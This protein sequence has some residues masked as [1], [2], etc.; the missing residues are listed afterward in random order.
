L[1]HQHASLHT[2][3]N[4]LRMQ[5]LGVQVML[6]FQFDALFQDALQ[7]PGTHEI[8][9]SVAGFVF[10]VLALALLLGAPSAHRLAEHGQPTARIQLL[11]QRYAA[12]ALVGLSGAMAA[13]AYL[14]SQ[15]HWGTAFAGTLAATLLVACGLTWYVFGAFIAR[16]THKRPRMTDD[17]GTE[18]SLSAEVDDLLTE[19]RVALPGAQALLGFQFIVTM[20]RPFEALPEVVKAIH[21]VGLACVTSSVL[22]LI[23]TAAI[24]RVAFGGRDVA[25]FL[26]I[27]S[28]VVTL[29]LAPLALG[30]AADVYVAAFKLFTND[31]IAWLS[32]GAA[33]AVLATFW[34]AIP[35]ALRTRRY[36]RR[37][38]GETGTNAT[39]APRSSGSARATQA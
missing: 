18:A 32:A 10:V 29:A 17:T 6:G 28:S 39:C 3:L 23:S 16:R 38:G 26:R 30:I 37:C 22:L 14:I 27:G 33:L 21:F 1:S 24:H 31:A 2:A 11:T 19:A 25:E 15:R 7:E 4:E 34:Y 20:T 12:G 5:M 36:A 35:L 8:A 13:N 9:A